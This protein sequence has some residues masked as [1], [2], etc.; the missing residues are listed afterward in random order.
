MSSSATE[1]EQFATFGRETIPLGMKQ[2]RVDKVFEHVATRYDFMND[3]MSGGL[4]RAWK[5]MLVDAANPPRNRT[6]HHLDVAGGTGDICLKLQKK[7]GPLTHS[8]LLDINPAMLDVAAER[9]DKEGL[10]KRIQIVEGNAEAL[11]FPDKSFDLYTIA[12]GIRN[13]PR[14]GLALQEAYR[15]LKTGGHFLCL[16]FS[17]TSVP[18]LEE[19][20]RFYSDRLI[21]KLGTW[22]AGDAAPY[23]YLKESIRRFPD[24]PDFAQK[25]RE[26]GF[27]QVSW[28]NFSGG[29]AALHSAW[30]I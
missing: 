14:M 24:Q 1:S 29:I 19:A 15:V 10:K 18:L 21:P 2:E 8:M 5:S 13:V 7:A 11:A 23:D 27:A 20:Y 16:E 12:F 28:R 26:V 9:I 6:F 4:H 30:R 17:H 22:F 25:L 3:I